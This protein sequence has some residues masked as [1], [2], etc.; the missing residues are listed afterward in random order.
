VDKQGNPREYFSAYLRRTY[1]EGHRQVVGLAVVL[2]GSVVV[3]GAARYKGLPVDPD[4]VDDEDW[5]ED[6]L[7]IIDA[8][9]GKIWFENGVGHR[10]AAKGKRSR[11]TRLVGVR[12][13]CED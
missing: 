6:H 12:D 4:D 1:R 11:P 7:E 8:E 13:R 2:R 5:D 3:A 9:P 10:C